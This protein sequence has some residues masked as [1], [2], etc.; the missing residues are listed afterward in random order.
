[1]EKS[2]H[3]GYA[4]TE[5][6]L[7]GLRERGR[8][9]ARTIRIIG[10]GAGNPEQITVQAVNALNT[11]DV[12][13]LL[14]KGPAKTKLNALRHEICRRYIGDRPVRYVEAD[15]PER[16]RS[17]PYASQVADLNA[18]KQD[19][20][21]RL[22]CEELK[23]G[24]TG[25]FLVWGDPALYDST[26]RL[27]SA[28]A[29]SG[30]HAIEW[31]VIPGVSSVAALTARCRVTLNRIGKPVEITTGRRL[32]E[33]FPA[34]ADTVVV[35]LDAEN[36]YK[37]LARDPEMEIWWGAY[38]GSDDEIIVSG[39]LSDVADE[40]ERVRAK[41]R[42]ANGWIMDSYLLRRASSED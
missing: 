14:D 31:D 33:G 25:G 18:R 12:V 6:D 7:E 42:E 27:V 32:A 13:F 9:L 41:A 15:N 2:R 22:I 8:R 24:E 19:V 17:G 29:D 10:I 40:I 36:A 1:M 11:L 20:F 38:V 34:H 26:V 5:T 3:P 28:I 23:D 37:G 35:M 4:A 21:E 39:R 16:E 30:R